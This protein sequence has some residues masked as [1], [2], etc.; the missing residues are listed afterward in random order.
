MW[1]GF[2]SPT[3]LEVQNQYEWEAQM[4]HALPP[5]LIGMPK[6]MWQE[7]V[8][9]RVLWP[10]LKSQFNGLTKAVSIVAVLAF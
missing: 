7:K 10:G 1:V 5:G 9:S 8:E 3:N 2:L 6:R 4:R